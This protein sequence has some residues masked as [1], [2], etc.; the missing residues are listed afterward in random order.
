MRDFLDRI[1][2]FKRPAEVKL[3]NGDKF[4]TAVRSGNLL[5]MKA[6]SLGK[7]D[8]DVNYA[9][10]QNGNT[11]LH[12]SVLSGKIEFV[13]LMMRLEPDPAAANIA[14][15][16]AIAIAV[17]KNF[18]RA[19]KIMIES[20]KADIEAVNSDGETVL[21]IALRV[22]QEKVARYLV[23]C[24]ANLDRSLRHAINAGNWNQIRWLC[25]NKANPDI[26]DGQGYTPLC[27]AIA[28]G[29]VGDLRL[30]ANLGSNLNFTGG[31]GPLLRL[32]GLSPL[33]V[34]IEMERREIIDEILARPGVELGTL[35]P[36]GATAISFA[37]RIG[38]M[39]TVRQIDQCGFKLSQSPPT[40]DGITPLMFA[41][42]SGRM[43]AVQWVVERETF[44][45]NLQDSIGWTAIFYATQRLSV[46]VV[47][48]LISR[49]AKVDLVSKDH[50]FNLRRVAMSQMS[51]LAPESY[52][53]KEVA[54][55][56]VQ[57]FSALAP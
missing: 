10:P 4:V 36:N 49:G 33:M 26:L 38:D 48:F 50:K 40:R 6:L 52:K 35:S 56:L 34:A 27:K 46:D 11:A 15:Q 1:I 21:N 24:G 9:D 19:I 57:R 42:Q 18:Q 31:N 28:D 45:I 30:W 16:T 23:D 43:E 51:K 3:V 25:A 44:S 41:A 7:A 17:E 55:E 8:L 12:Y 39:R 37:L 20:K 14:G 53:Q 2:H 5:A 22:Q 13:E 29:A 32:K 54:K 47:D